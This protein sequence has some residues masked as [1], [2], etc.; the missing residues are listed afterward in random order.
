MSRARRFRERAETGGWRV[1]ASVPCGKLEFMA[2]DLELIRK[3]LLFFK[4]KDDPSMVDKP[5][6]GAEYSESV[7]Q[8]HLRLMHQAGLMNCE[9]EKSSTSDRIIRV[10][11]FDL[12]WEGHEFLAKISADGV[13]PKLKAMLGS[14]GG[15]VAFAVINQLATKLALQAAGLP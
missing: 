13:W 4:E 5:D 6:V 2:R 14:K 7:V 10:Y 8:Y 9:V 12:T 15:S 3:L 11:P 1:P